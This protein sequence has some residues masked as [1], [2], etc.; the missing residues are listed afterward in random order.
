MV[1]RSAERGAASRG[2]TDGVGWLINTGVSL[3]LKGL[4]M[5]LLL[6]AG[7]LVPVRADGVPAEA[8]RNAA[9]ATTELG[10]QVLR[11]NFSYIFQRMY[12]RFK[13]RAAKKAGGE[14]K[15]AEQLGKMPEQMIA[16]G[17]RILSFK[18]GEPSSGFVLPEMREWLVFVPTTKVYMVQDQ[19]R[20]VNR[21]FESKG[22]QVAVAKEGGTDWYFIDG[23][24][25]TVQELRSIFPTLPKDEKQLNLPLVEQKEIK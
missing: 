24:N 11:T 2:L 16:E 6:T 1:R 14:E 22:Y 5:I 10:D 21:R 25:L 20:G 8:F 19:E 15:L 18:V 13:A 23:A 7:A 12:P 3:T 9:A 17:I 4:M